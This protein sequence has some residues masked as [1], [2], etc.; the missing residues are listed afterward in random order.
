MESTGFVLTRNH[1]DLILQIKTELQGNDLTHTVSRCVRPDLVYF[2]TMLKLLGIWNPNNT[3]SNEI[4]RVPVVYCHTASYPAD[5]R[6]RE[7]EFQ[8]LSKDMMVEFR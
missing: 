8:V 7:A 5:D 2:P 4:L 3:S 1:A 6:A